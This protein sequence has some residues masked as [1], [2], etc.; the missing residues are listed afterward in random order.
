MFTKSFARRFESALRSAGERVDILINGNHYYK[1]VVMENTGKNFMR[2]YDDEHSEQR[3]I[4]YRRRRDKL[5]FIP[6]IKS[7]DNCVG[8]VFITARGRRYRV[9]A[10]SVVR[11]GDEPT[12][13]WA[14]G[15]EVTKSQ[16]D[17][18]DDFD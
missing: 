6:Y 8:D 17:Y 15:A 18:Y 11:F 14:I 12:Y 16:G 9:I 13:I 5:F 2:K 4:G 7:M 10:D 3:R 1:R